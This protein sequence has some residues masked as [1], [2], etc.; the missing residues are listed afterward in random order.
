MSCDLC[1]IRIVDARRPKVGDIAM[2]T[3]VGTYIQ[4]GSLLG[5]LP[6]VTVEGALAP[7]AAAG[8]WEEELAVG[9]V[10]VDLSFEEPGE[11]GGD[12]DYAAGVLLAVVGLGALED[13]ALVG[14]A[15]NLEGLGVKVFG[16]KGQDLG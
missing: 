14:G 8:G 15:A 7:E 1:E 11:G 5:W 9:A 16:P 4:P 3:L 2:A 13:A 6:D 12:R 10:E